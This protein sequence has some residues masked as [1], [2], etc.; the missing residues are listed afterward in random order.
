MK[1]CTIIQN[2]VIST[3]LKSEE[4]DK[5]NCLSLHEVLFYSRDFKTNKSYISYN[6]IIELLG[7]S[8]GRISKTIK[9]LESLGIIEYDRGSNL[10]HKTN[11]FSFLALESSKKG[12]KA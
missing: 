1:N 3:I 12:G 10:V 6:K 7:W 4:V 9:E 5:A 2:E 8:R 11:S